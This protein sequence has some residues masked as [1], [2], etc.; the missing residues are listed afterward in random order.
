M[1]RACPR[2]KRARCVWRTA[3]D[4][5]GAR[6]ARNNPPLTR[7]ISSREFAQTSRRKGCGSAAQ[8]VCCLAAPWARRWSPPTG[9]RAR[10]NGWRTSKASG[11]A[12]RDAT[13][14]R[15][16]RL[17]GTPA[18]AGANEGG[19]YRW[20]DGTQPA[21]PVWGRGIASLLFGSAR[22]APYERRQPACLLQ[23][24][25]HRRIGHGRHS[26]ATR[27]WKKSKRMSKSMLVRSMASTEISRMPA[28]RG[29]DDDG[30]QRDA[31]ACT[32]RARRACVPVWRTPCARTAGEA[33]EGAHGD[34]E[35]VVSTHRG[36]RR[37]VVRW[38]LRLR[39]PAETL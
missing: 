17:S 37:H 7:R 30:G 12:S 20:N 3:S 21:R 13:A 28:R 27:C 6:A 16:P 22:S 19:A 14:V 34:G 24:A 39:R 8:S 5:A 9:L 10:A 33:Q 26:Q 11:T 25:H 35:E 15:R 32:A 31:H 38:A 18:V 1:V 4:R 23:T 36:T 2:S 29:H